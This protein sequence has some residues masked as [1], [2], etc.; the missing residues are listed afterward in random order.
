MFLHFSV[1]LILF[2]K[3]KI[4]FPQEH[5]DGLFKCIENNLRELGV[6]DVGVNKKMKILNKIFYDILLK[7][8]LPRNDFKINKS[9]VLKY[10][11]N[12]DELNDSKYELFNDYFSNFYHFCFELSPQT[13]IKDALKFKDK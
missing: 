12:L 8:D 6:G 9:I 4:N 7:I 11:D 1:I 3:K 13:M 5:Y 2:K 10:F